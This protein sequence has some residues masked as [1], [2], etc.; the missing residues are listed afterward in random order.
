MVRRTLVRTVVR[1]GV[2]VHSGQPGSVC[3]RP[4]PFGE[5]LVAQL[6][7]GPV[8]IGWRSATAGAGCTVIAGPSGEVH[9]A[10]HLLA[11]LDAL[12]VTDAILEVQGPEIPILDGSAL[13]WIEALDEAGVV[14]GPALQPLQLPQVRVE[15][16]GG[17]A[18]AGPGPDRIAVEVDFGASG[19]RGA[20][21]V[22]RTADAFCREIAW[23]RT[24]VRAADVLS[25][26][27]AG[28]GLGASE[29]NTVIWPTSPLRAGDEPVRHKL[30][31]AW[32]DLSLLGPVSGS[33][34][35]VRGSH[36]LHLALI[37][38]IVEAWGEPPR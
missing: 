7:S 2:G 22:A 34:R 20:L 21:A 11:A 13:G 8:P 18:C 33:V 38:R 27:A 3:L 9:T 16:A 37:A 36:A 17:V 6:P 5:G 19:P 28:R 24:F 15:A 12:G 23:A 26:R 10:E 25:L 32:G 29:D 4:A 14:S 35:V 31:D 30:L 1:D